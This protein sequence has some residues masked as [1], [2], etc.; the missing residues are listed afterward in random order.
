MPEFTLYSRPECH[1]CQDL[2]QELRLLQMELG[3]GLAVVDI[4][5]DPALVERWGRRVPVLTCRGEVVCE[6]FLDPAAVRAICCPD[7]RV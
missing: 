1:L 4:D 6:V 3:F 7:E 5:R 2:E